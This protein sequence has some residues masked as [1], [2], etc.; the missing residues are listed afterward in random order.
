MEVQMIIDSTV[1]E[2]LQTKIAGITVVN[3][4]TFIL[5]LVVSVILGKVVRVNIHRI[6]KEKIPI[7]TLV[8]VEKMAYYII[9]FIGF[10][11][12]LPYIGFSLGGLLVAGGILGIVIGFASQTVVSN[13]ISGIFLLIEKPMAVG[14]GV[15][16]GGVSGVVEDI[17][18]LSTT[19][20]TYDGIYVR[21][22]NDKVFS[23]NIQNYVAHEARRFGYTIGISYKDDAEKAVE[24][25]K[26]LL[27]EHPLVLKNPS[28]TIFVEKL[29]DSS[30]NY[31][32]RV[33]ARSEDY[34]DVFFD[35]TEAIKLRFD[36]EGISI[37]YPQQDVHLYQQEKK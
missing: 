12:A 30:V 27:D 1:N 15:E 21:L 29:G 37:P 2:I 14:D 16:I 36:Q 13:L 26:R 8:V 25:I 22:P 3:L 28:P 10:M 20:R 7:T 23:S 33:W 34:W 11:V 35:T 5:I 31:T 18:I 32:V 24:I 4:L 9:V 17:R 19:V 6:M